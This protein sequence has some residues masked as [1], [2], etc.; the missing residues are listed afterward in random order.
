MRSD[1]FLLLHR[2]SSL[3]KNCRVP[4]TKLLKLFV[5]LV[6]PVMHVLL[7]PFALSHC[8]TA[9]RTAPVPAKEPHGRH[10][11]THTST[12]FD[13]NCSS[14]PLGTFPVAS[15]TQVITAHHLPLHSKA[16]KKCSTRAGGK[17]MAHRISRLYFGYVSATRAYATPAMGN[18]L[19]L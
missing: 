13:D 8:F 6:L 2:F 16:R 9:G 7:L 15:I 19:A 17:V 12:A 14:K 10:T 18:R 5:P 4:P 1:W 11:H 3:Q